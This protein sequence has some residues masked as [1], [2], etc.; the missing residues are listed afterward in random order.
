MDNFSEALANLTD[1][2]SKVFSCAAKM[3]VDLAETIED[4]IDAYYASFDNPRRKRPPK[5]ITM[6]SQRFFKKQRV[7]KCRNNC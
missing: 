6:A 3:I 2:I 7:Y 1:A 5:C 4:F